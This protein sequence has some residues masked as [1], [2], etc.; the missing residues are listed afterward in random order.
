MEIPYPLIIKF[1][2]EESSPEEMF[3]QLNR[4]YGVEIAYTNAPVQIRYCLLPT[5]ISSSSSYFP[6]FSNPGNSHLLIEL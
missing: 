3:K 2:N 6:F 5:S 1:L 4:W